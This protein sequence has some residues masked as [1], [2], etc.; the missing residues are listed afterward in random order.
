MEGLNQQIA[1][2]TAKLEAIEAELSRLKDLW[3]LELSQWTS[4]ELGMFSE[5]GQRD[6]EA[7]KEE[8][9]QLRKEKEQLMKKE[10]QLMK[11][12]EQLNELIILEKKNQQ[13]GKKFILL[14]NNNK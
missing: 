10:E 6:K 9:R 8:K 4:R 13:A 7:L 12:E 2:T 11:K 14:R 1:T 5:N 3:D